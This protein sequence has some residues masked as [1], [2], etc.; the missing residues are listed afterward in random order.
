MS[1]AGEGTYPLRVGCRGI[2]SS[3]SLELLQLLPPAALPGPPAD[4]VGGRGFLT[5]LP[6]QHHLNWEPPG[7]PAGMLPG[8]REALSGHPP[9]PEGFLPMDSK[10]SGLAII[11]PGRWAFA[12]LVP[13]FS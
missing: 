10:S 4:H 2:G 12:L 7:L 5:Q 3:E 9:G 1:E 13:T 11:L 8:A 6:L